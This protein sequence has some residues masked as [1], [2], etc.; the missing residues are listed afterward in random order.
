MMNQAFSSSENQAS[1][2]YWTPPPSPLVRFRPDRPRQ[3]E[4]LR[5]LEQ[6]VRPTT[7]K[8]YQLK[9]KRG[10]EPHME[11]EPTPTYNPKK[12]KKKLDELNR[13]ISHSEKKHDGLIHKQNSIKKVIE[14]LKRGNAKQPTLEPAQ[15][16]IEYE[17]AFGR[18]YRSYRVNGRSRMDVETFFDRTRGELISLITRELTD[19]NSVMVQ[20]TREIRF[21]QEFDDAVE[22]DRVELAFN[23]RMMNLYRGSNLDV[24][25]DGMI[26]HMK[27]QIENPALLNSRFRFNAVLFLDSNFHRLDLT[28]GSSYLPLPDWIAKKKYLINN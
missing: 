23:S 21:V 12:L 25:V 8:P 16:F 20:T 2:T 14:E 3:P 4:L 9:T 26:T 27:A 6:P 19:L 1:K 22:N 7:F 17:R 5:Q 24:L 10:K 13:K 15:V 28:R 11:Q 18:A